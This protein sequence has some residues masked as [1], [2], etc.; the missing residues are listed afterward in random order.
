MVSMEKPLASQIVEIIKGAEPHVGALARLVD[1]IDDGKERR[2][3]RRQIA[4]VMLAYLDLL[5]S[6]TTQ[7]PELEPEPKVSGGEII[8][9]EIDQ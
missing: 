3:L 5:S 2:A 1:S 7:Y 4:Q 6:V 8:V 9:G